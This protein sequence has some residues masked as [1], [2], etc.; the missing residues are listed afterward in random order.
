MVSN[1]NIPNTARQIPN[2]PE[3]AVVE[4]NAVFARDSIRPIYAGPLKEDIYQLILPHVMNHED[5]LK[6][7]L[8]C[9][10]DVIYRAF[11]RDPLVTCSAADAD[12]LLKTMIRNTKKYLPEGWQKI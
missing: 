2:L 4:T 11:R 10:Y 8:T 3:T 6:G 5:V 12:E 9:D 7:A 1:V